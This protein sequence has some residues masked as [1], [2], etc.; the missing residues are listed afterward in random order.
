MDPNL[1]FEALQYSVGKTQQE[2]TF[3]EKYLQQ[4]KPFFL[5]KCLYRRNIVKDIF[6]LFY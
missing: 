3:A 2:I 4:V 5:L 6:K 1:V